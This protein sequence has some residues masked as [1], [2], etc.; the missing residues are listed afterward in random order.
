MVYRDFKDLNGKTA[1][2]KV[3]RDKVFIFAKNLKY[4][5][6]QHGLPSMVYKLFD[7]KSSG[8]VIKNKSIS[9]KQLAE[10]LN[11][12]VIRKSNKRK[13]H[14]HFIDNI[15]GVDLSDMQLISKFSGGFRFLLCFINI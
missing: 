13:V 8:S 6:C 4:D 11:K 1:A 9:N 15:W 3:L 7:K 5:G 14:S 10:E 12:P 2:D